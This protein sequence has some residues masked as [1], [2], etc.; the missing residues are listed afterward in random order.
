MTNRKLA[1]RIV[2]TLG[3]HLAPLQCTWGDEYTESYYELFGYPSGKDPNGPY[4]EDMVS[5]V[6]SI[7]CKRK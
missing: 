1:E 6:E 7:L 5:D 3:Q 2:K 4:W